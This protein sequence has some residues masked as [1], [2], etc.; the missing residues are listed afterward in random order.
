VEAAEEEGCG[1]RGGVRPPV[2]CGQEAAEEEGRGMR[3]ASSG[4]MRA[5]EV[6]GRGRLRLFTG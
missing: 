1:M 5:I 2:G 4:G 3:G 6:V